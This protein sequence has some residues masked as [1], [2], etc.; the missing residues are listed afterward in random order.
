[1]ELIR[2]FHFIPPFLIYSEKNSFLLFE[3][4][5]DSLLAMMLDVLRRKASSYIALLCVGCCQIRF[6][7]AISTADI[8]PIEL[9]KKTLLSTIT[10]ESFF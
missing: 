4:R 8:S 9:L 5:T 1:M 10:K 6:P 2:C 3:N 7:V